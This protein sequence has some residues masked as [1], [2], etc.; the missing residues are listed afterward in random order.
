MPTNVRRAS[1]WVAV[2]VV[3]QLSNLAAEVLAER[4]PSPGLRGFVSFIHR[5]KA[6]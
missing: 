1:F 6:D 3:A 2:A 4:L 5:G